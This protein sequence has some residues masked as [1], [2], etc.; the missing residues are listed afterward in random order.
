VI[1]RVVAALAL[2]AVAGC[3]RGIP[4]AGSVPA[5]SNATSTAATA[6][7]LAAVDRLFTGMRT[8]DT[9]SLRALLAPEIVFY[10]SRE[11][12]GTWAT[13]QRQMV[14]QFLRTVATGADELRERIWSPEVRIDGEIATVWAPY[15][16]HIGNKFSHCGTDTF[17]LVRING[18]WSITGLTYTVRL[19]GC[20]APSTT[21]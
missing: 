6:E 9:A 8:R 10:S 12:G 20:S 18:A 13:T 5:A 11:A 2:T 1:R 16:F 15:D 17:Q 7:V 19:R 4:I 14:P 3:S 21:R